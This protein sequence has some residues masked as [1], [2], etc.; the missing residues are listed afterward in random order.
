MLPSLAREAKGRRFRLIGIG[1]R[2]FVAEDAAEA[3]DLF[4]EAASRRE[5][6]DLAVDA[7]RARFGEKALAK[8]RTLA[9]KPRP[10]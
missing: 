9:P 8:G 10:K 1:A 6:L 7:I 4:G 5:G 2:D 3:P